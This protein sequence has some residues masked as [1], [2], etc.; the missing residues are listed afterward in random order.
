MSSCDLQ[1]PVSRLTA[2]ND[3]VCAKQPCAPPC[4]SAILWESVRES[5]R[6]GGRGRGDSWGNPRCHIQHLFGF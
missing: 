3:A 4:V 2:S 5:E 6:E 1:R